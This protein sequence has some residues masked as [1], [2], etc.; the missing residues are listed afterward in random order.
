MTK[1]IN[2]I[3][4]REQHDAVLKQIEEPKVG[5]R[6]WRINALGIIARK[7][8]IPKKV[9]VADAE[10]INILYSFDG[11]DSQFTE[12][13]L[14]AA[15]SSYYA[16]DYL[17]YRKVLLE[18]L[19][20]INLRPLDKPKKRTPLAK[21]L[22]PWIQAHPYATQKEAK[23]DPDLKI[24]HRTIAEH[25]KECG[26]LSPKERVVRWF[27]DHPDATVQMCITEDA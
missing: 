8:K 13:D 6:C 1:P 19:A 25:W 16:P 9:Y 18:K 10:R 7:L 11:A 22:R 26:G 14:M 3:P 24:S 17:S 21:V 2:W 12:E 27:D 20:D 15:I 4:E 23:S 5:Y